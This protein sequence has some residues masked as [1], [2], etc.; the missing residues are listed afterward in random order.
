M[1]TK[2]DFLAARATHP[3]GWQTVRVFEDG[4]WGVMTGHGMPLDLDG[5]RLPDVTI[6]R[7]RALNHDVRDMTKEQMDLEEE[8]LKAADALYMQ[9]VAG[10]LRAITIRLPAGAT[11]WPTWSR[12]RRVEMAKA[13]L[14]GRR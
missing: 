6:S 8:R 1:R 3:D 7:E 4:K 10:G 12:E 13:V 11:D 2:E 5:Y 14:Y 9:L